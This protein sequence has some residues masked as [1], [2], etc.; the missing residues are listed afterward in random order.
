MEDGI[1][2][3]AIKRQHLRSCITLQRALKFRSV[4][5]LKVRILVKES[6]PFRETI[7]VQVSCVPGMFM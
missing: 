7:Q 6:Y 5:P 3:N 2:M 1:D 4:V